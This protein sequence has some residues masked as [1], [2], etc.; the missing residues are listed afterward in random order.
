MTT[1]PPYRYQ[2]VLDDCEYSILTGDGMPDSLEAAKD[3]ITTLEDECRAKDAEL[4][5]YSDA[6]VMG[7][8]NLADPE[9]VVGVKQVHNPSEICWQPLIVKP[10]APKDKP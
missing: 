8:R 10:T 9:W 6:P 7:L 1:K 2:K 5:A 3:A 4:A